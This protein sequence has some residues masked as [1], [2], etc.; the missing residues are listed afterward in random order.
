MVLPPSFSR[1][2]GEIETVEAEKIGWIYLPRGTFYPTLPYTYGNCTLCE[3]RCTLWRFALHPLWLGIRPR[4]RCC[5]ARGLHCYW[6]STLWDFG[7]TTGVSDSLC[8]LR[9]GNTEN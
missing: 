9:Y 5:S 6:L 8:G 2:M 3:S 1:K 4:H 7:L